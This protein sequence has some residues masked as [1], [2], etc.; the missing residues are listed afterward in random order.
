MHNKLNF[1]K[2]MFFFLIYL[3]R[4]FLRTKL[5]SSPTFRTYLVV[6]SDFIAKGKGSIVLLFLFTKFIGALASFATTPDFIHSQIPMKAQLLV[7][8]V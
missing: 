6:V 2:V 5:I 4:L 8:K 1:K 7:L 3:K